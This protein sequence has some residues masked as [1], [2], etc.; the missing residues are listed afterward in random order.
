[1]KKTNRLLRGVSQFASMTM[2]SRLLGFVR[3]VVFA[4]LFGAGALM[5]AFFVAFKIPNFLRRL[6]AEGAFSQAFIPVL[7]SYKENEDHAALRNFVANMSGFLALVVGAL[8]LLMMYQAPWVIWVFAPGFAAQPDTMALAVHLL[9]I[10]LPYLWLITLTAMGAAI[11]NSYGHFALPAFNPVWLNISL[12]TSA[13]VGYHYANP[14]ALALAWGVLLAGMIQWLFQWPLLHRQGLL[15]WPKWGWRDSGVRQVL[16]MMLPALFGIAVTQVNLLVNT[17]FA[18]FLIKGSV[19][20]LYYADRLA[21]L[22]LGVIGVALAT[23][24]MPTLSTCHVKKQP[25]QFQEALAWGCR[26][27]IMAGV[28]SGIGLCLLSGPII[29][30]L[31]HYGQFN[32]QDALHTTHCLQ[33]MALGIPA[34]ML[35]KVLVSACYAKRDVATPVRAGILAVMVNILLNLL[36]VDALAHVG[37]ALALT[38]SAYINVAVLWFVLCSQGRLLS[39][40]ILKGVWWR[41]LVI[42]NGLMVGFIFYAQGD[43]STWLQV[44][45]WARIGWLIFILVVAKI[46]YVCGLWLAGLRRSDLASPSSSS[47][48]DG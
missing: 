16:S 22:P 2:I 20:W 46:S 35:V 29:I 42:A 27:S 11:L 43:V 18:S 3:D 37:L 32:A 33:A 13:Y 39:I 40:Q 34:F 38:V 17:I 6:C 15:G 10:M 47:T 30:T 23:V 8:V 5:D 7:T 24:L 44:G 41:C 31:F 19:S 12:I 48:S 28:P 9:Q 21:N 1:M 36:W 4:Y 14:P 25:L 45:T 26:W